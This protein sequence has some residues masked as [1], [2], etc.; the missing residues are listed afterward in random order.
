M[1][2]KSDKRM[3]AISLEKSVVDFSVCRHSVIIVRAFAKLTQYTRTL[4]VKTRATIVSQ[5]EGTMETTAL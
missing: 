2:V 3:Q 5:N 1:R 4:T